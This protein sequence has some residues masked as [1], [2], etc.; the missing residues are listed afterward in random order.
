MLEGAR[1]DTMRIYG[2]SH[3]GEVR[4]N[5]F[6]RNMAA[7]GYHGDHLQIYGINGEAVC[8]YDLVIEQNLMHDDQTGKAV[9]LVANG[10]AGTASRAGDT[11]V[12]A[13]AQGI[14]IGAAHKTMYR[15]VSIRHNLIRVGMKNGIFISAGIENCPIEENILVPVAGQ[16]LVELVLNKDAKNQHWH[17]RG[18][19]VRGNIV[20]KIMD[21]GGEAKVLANHSYGADPSGLFAGITPT[22]GGQV[23][24]DYRPAKGSPVVAPW[25]DAAIARLRL[26]LDS[27][28]R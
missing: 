6:L 18:V 11:G 23:P 27:V 1:E 14:F 25:L 16:S 12:P 15:G 28:A 9:K 17:N 8:P 19:T 21:E 22:S 7:K 26:T 10:Q 5:V 2:D 13:G 24:E 4:G 3:D 20:T